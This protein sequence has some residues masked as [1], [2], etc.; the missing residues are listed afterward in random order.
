MVFRITILANLAV[1]GLAAPV[2]SR[3]LQGGGPQRAG[4][5]PPEDGDGRSQP[6]FYR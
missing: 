1:A 3:I 6:Y 2:G 5:D 4:R